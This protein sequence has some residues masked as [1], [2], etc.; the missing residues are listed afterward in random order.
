MNIKFIILVVV[1]TAVA[2]F[3]AISS[4]K[5]TPPDIPTTAQVTTTKA[6]EKKP[7]KTE[8]TQP[9]SDESETVAA[10]VP[11]DKFKVSAPNAGLYNLSDNM[12]LYEKNAEKKI[13]PASLTK[14][15]TAITALTYMDADEVITVGTELDLVPKG[16]SL[17][18]ISKGHRLTLK[19]L[20]KGMLLASGNDAAYTIAVNVGRHVMDKPKASDKEALAHFI[21]LMNSLAKTIGCTDSNFT[22]PDGSDSEGQ[23]TTVEELALICNHAYN[24]RT[25]REVVA[26]AKTNVVFESGQHITWSTTN[27]LMHEGSEFYLPGVVGIKTGT[28]ALAGSCLIAVAEIDGQLYLSIVAGC[29]DDSARYKTT[30]KLLA[31]PTS[32]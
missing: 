4:D 19:D 30:K 20:M 26:I 3:F 22:T 28:T 23:Y 11:G 14:I 29:K 10:T 2:L 12:V 27:K 15:L 17:C 9:T 8:S 25:I 13:A 1:L 32:M 18:L 6:P 21:G 31:Y 24:F 16:S 5:Q 7:E